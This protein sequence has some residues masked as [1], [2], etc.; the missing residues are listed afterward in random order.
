MDQIKKLLTALSLGQKIGLIAVILAIAIGVPTFTKWQHES[1][2][3][4]LFTGMSPEDAG[5]IV[6]K[7]KESGVA[8]RLADNGTSVLVPADKVDEVRLE[9][10]GAGLPKTGR[11]GF[12][13]FDKTNI[14]LTDFTEHVN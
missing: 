7:L 4:P 3:K 2:F 1:S 13:L 11:I 9:L 10:A 12:E 6:Q 14:S 5:A 8:H